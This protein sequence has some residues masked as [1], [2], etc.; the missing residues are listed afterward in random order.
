MDADLL[1][2]RSYNIEITRIAIALISY[3]Q[4]FYFYFK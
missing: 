2:L 4:I 3:L 1:V